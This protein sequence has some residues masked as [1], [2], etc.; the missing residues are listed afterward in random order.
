MLCVWEGR[1]SNTCRER[2]LLPGPGVDSGLVCPHTFA[3]SRRLFCRVPTHSVECYCGRTQTCCA[4]TACQPRG[5][6]GACVCGS[7]MAKACRSCPRGPRPEP[8]PEARCPKPL[9]LRWSDGGCEAAQVA[10]M[11][12]SH[13]GAGPAEGGVPVRYWGQ[14]RQ[15]GGGEVPSVMVLCVVSCWS[16]CPHRTPMPSFISSGL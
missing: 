8:Q 13:R 5:G 7:V 4:P 3:H 6:G 16:C 1:G 10:I 12:L 15:P 2:A 11:G 9:L 14:A